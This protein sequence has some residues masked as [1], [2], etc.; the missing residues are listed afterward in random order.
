M[1]AA[2]GCCRRDLHFSRRRSSSALTPLFRL[3]HGIE[4]CLAGSPFAASAKEIACSYSWACRARE[5]AKVEYPR[6]THSL[7]RQSSCRCENLK[8]C[9]GAAQGSHSLLCH[10]HVFLRQRRDCSRSAR[11]CFNCSN[12]LAMAPPAAGWLVQPARWSCGRRQ[13]ADW[14]GAD[15]PCCLATTDRPAVTCARASLNSLINC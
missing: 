12:N 6:Q 2:A 13:I 3:P 15:R 7:I 14:H 5:L 11:A 8:L 1:V 10:A 4:F 9:F